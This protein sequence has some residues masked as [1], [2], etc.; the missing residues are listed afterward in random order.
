MKWCCGSAEGRFQSRLTSGEFLVAG[1]ARSSDKTWFYYGFNMAERKTRDDVLG[2]IR[3][4]REVLEAQGLRTFQ[5]Q[6][7]GCV[8]YCQTCGV[9]LLDHYGPDGGALRDDAYVRAMWEQT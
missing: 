5:L 4:A 8:H 6:A 9:K 7:F 2:A 1:P 3:A